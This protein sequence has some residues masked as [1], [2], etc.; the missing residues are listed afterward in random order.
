MHLP[1]RE[2]DL[3][4]LLAFFL[5]VMSFYRFLTWVFPASYVLTTA[6][7][8]N[9]TLEAAYAGSRKQN[10]GAFRPLRSTHRPADSRSRRF[11]DHSLCDLLPVGTSQSRAGDRVS[12]RRSRSYRTRPPASAGPSTHGRRHA[13]DERFADRAGDLPALSPDQN[14]SYVYGFK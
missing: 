1:W 10:S 13:G 4:L 3:G 6:P 8:L 14:R 9:L 12:P 5:Q 2:A 11:P 7:N